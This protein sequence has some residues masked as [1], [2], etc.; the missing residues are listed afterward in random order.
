[1]TQTLSF[2]QSLSWIDD[3]DVMSKGAF[4]FLMFVFTL[5][6]TGGKD[7]APIVTIPPG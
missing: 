7:G 3:K 1:M 5:T 4:S 2:T 6:E